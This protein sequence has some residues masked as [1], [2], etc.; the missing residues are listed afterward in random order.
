[1][2]DV[3]TKEKRS[4]V[5]SAIRGWGNKATELRLISIMRKHGVT[6][7]RRNKPLFGRPDF[8][9]P[10]FRLAVFVDG[11]FWHCC[12][13]HSVKP[14]NN[15]KFWRDKFQANKKRDQ[16]VNKTLKKSGWNVLRIWEHELQ[17]KFESK[18]VKRILNSL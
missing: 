9:F 2:A 4:K 14:K 12:P 5:M 10:K 1:M 7:W 13:I 3:F 6:G 17:V 16:I 18:V 8:V 11:C 15:P